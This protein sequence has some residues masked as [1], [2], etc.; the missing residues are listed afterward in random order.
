MLKKSKNN[1]SVL[2]VLI[3]S[4]LVFC[5][6]SFSFSQSSDTITITTYYPSPYGSY[7]EMRATRLAIGDTYINGSQ[8]CWSPD[9][10]T[11]QVYSDL[12][13]D[14]ILDS[15]ED[16]VD[17]IVEGNVGIGT[18]KPQT[19]LEVQGGA[20]KASGGLI[21]ETRTSDPANPATGQVWLRTDITP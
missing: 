14:N 6:T 10:C 1:K 9:T 19:K 4:A 11:N 15:G 20:I 12:D 13:S 16:I 7:R 5:L 21:V 8:Y 17:L 18:A 2:S 3:F